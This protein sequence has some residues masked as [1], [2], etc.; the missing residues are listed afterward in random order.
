MSDRKSAHLLIE[1]PL[2]LPEEVAGE[3]SAVAIRFEYTVEASAGSFLIPRAQHWDQQRKD[4]FFRTFDFPCRRC[5]A[6][7]AFL[8]ADKSYTQAEASFA[9]PG[10][11]ASMMY[12]PHPFEADRISVQVLEQ[13]RKLKL[14]V[15]HPMPG[16]TYGVYWQVWLRSASAAAI[17]DA[18]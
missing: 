5:S 4:N 11:D 1:S 17:A 16:I 8:G 3:D 7:I 14:E 6:E 13:N 10:R 12:S 15:I 9:L 2:R 18:Q